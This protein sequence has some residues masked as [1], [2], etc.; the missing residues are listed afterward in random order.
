M[1]IRSTA[2]QE[3]TRSNGHTNVIA[4]AAMPSSASFRGH[5]REQSGGE[6]TNLVT[7]K[8]M[9]KGINAD[10]LCPPKERSPRYR[11]RPYMNAA[12]S[13]ALMV[14]S[15]V[16]RVPLVLL[17]VVLLRFGRVGC[18]CDS[19]STGIAS[20]GGVPRAAGWPLNIFRTLEYWLLLPRH[21]GARSPARL[22][23]NRRRRSS[24]RGDD[25][26]LARVER[27]ASTDRPC[28]FLTAH[29]SGVPINGPPRGLAAACCQ[30]GTTCTL[31]PCVPPERWADSLELR[32]LGPLRL[33][34][35]FVGRGAKSARARKGPQRQIA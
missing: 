31:V 22:R 16:F 2:I 1:Q 15:F 25:S 30:S 20:A 9:R 13:I 4:V 5:L 10:L 34:R 33:R 8:Q 18:I 17:R 12:A 19:E 3:A 35:A 7:E 28:S 27:S 14:T 26:G 24:E 11:Q 29:V 21:G 23:F 32:V 6:F